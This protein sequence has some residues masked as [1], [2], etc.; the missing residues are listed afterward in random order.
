MEAELQTKIKN[1]IKKETIMLFMK[2]TP[3][4]PACG[5]SMQTVDILNKHNI[6]FGSFDVYSDEEV[7]QGIKKY[8]NWPTFPQL[9]YKGNLIGGFDIIKELDETNKLKETLQN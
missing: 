1:I 8:S 2:G 5:F 4:E 6:T 7:R 9:Y 3:Q